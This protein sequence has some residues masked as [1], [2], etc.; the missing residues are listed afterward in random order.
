M[1]ADKTEG[2]AQRRQGCTEEG[3]PNI[4]DFGVPDI[5]NKNPIMALHEHRP[6][7]KYSLLHETGME[8][9]KVFTMCVDIDRERYEGCRPTKQR[10]KYNAA[11]AALKKAFQ[12]SETKTLSWR[13]TSIG[14]AQNTRCSTR[15]AK[16]IK[17][18]LQCSWILTVSGTRGVGRQNRGPSTTPPRL[19]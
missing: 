6:S 1:W 3:V 14:R 7:S 12:I 17:K 10:A 4:C 11:K 9:K 15:P 16:T 19:H 8:H 5:G 18:Y 2:Q 13:C